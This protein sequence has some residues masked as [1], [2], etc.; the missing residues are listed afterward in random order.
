[1]TETKNYGLYLESNAETNFLEWRERMNGE[2]GS[3]MVKI[4]TVLFEKANKSTTATAVLAA[5]NW[6][7]TGSKFTQQITV[8]GMTKTQNGNITISQTATSEQL[9]AAEVALLSVATQE[10]GKLTVS[11]RGIKPDV[12]IP[13]YVIFIN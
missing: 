6:T 2:S 4:D 13:V 12:D 1:M 11:A 8:D 5:D 7:E 10:D 9:E 3:N